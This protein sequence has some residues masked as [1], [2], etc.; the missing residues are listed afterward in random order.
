M[1]NLHALATATHQRP[2]DIVGIDDRW[3]AYQF[4]AAVV[5]VG[6]TVENAL[7]E[8]SESGGKMT[9]RY[10]SAQ[11]LDAGFRLPQPASAADALKAMATKSKGVRYHKVK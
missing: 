3:A 6:T 9:P 5:L 2:S 8:M 4:D 1:W 11:L 10:T 7:Q